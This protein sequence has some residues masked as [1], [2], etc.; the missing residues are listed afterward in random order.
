ME[1]NQIICGDCLEVMEDIPSDYIDLTVTSPPYNLGNNHHTGNNR[2]QTYEDNLP[3][4]EYQKQQMEV[5]NEIFRITKKGGYIVFEEEVNNVRI[6]SR[7]IYFLSK[8]ANKLN[9]RCKFFEAGKV[10]VSFMTHKEIKEIME[11]LKDT[12]N[13]EILKK[14]YVPWK[15]SLK[16]KLTLLMSNVGHV[17]YVIKK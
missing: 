10:V 7:I 6:F 15:M 1:Y 9:L 4:H 3:E 11:N 16:W 5:L 14:K 12:Y 13:F 2:H 8:I 17:F